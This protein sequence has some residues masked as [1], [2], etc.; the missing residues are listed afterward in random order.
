MRRWI[1]LAAK[2]YTRQWR[3]RYG[4]EF[5]AL[6]EDVEP[7][8]AEFVNVLGGAV[9]MQ[10][11]N[12]TAYLK[13]AAV[14]AV[15]GAVAG[16]GVSLRVPDRYTASA[17]IK[18][19][20]GAED[21]PGKT[22]EHLTQMQQE[23]LSRNSLA[24]LIQ[25]PALNLYQRERR[26]LPLEDI[27]QNMRNKDIRIAPAPGDPSV[28][29]ISFTYP[30][31]RLAQAV[32]QQLVNRFME[33]NAVVNKQRQAMWRNAWQ[34]DGPPGPAMEVVAQPSDPRK[35]D[36]TGRLLFVA[37]GINKPNL[38]YETAEQP[39]AGIYVFSPAG[40]QLEFI[41]IPRD[42]TT[43]C[44][45]GGDELKTLFITAGGSLWSVKVNTP[46]HPVWPRLP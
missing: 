34:E 42:E 23:I 32:T 40:A 41:P 14:L 24:E 7:D 4:A 12:E 35:I 17:A 18:V 10:L 30:D 38:P 11:K 37:A 39:T 33:T 25:R 22:V 21:D 43:N 20:P 45:F 8:W 31:R 6:M 27:V 16:L 1:G 28:M 36:G 29:N 44:A 3:A 13:L 2:L 26:N 19:T 46:G 5:D 9:Q 15:I